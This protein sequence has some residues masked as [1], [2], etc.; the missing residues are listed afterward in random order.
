MLKSLDHV[1]IRTHQLGGLTS[2]YCD[3]LGMTTGPRPSFSFGGAWIYCA[4]RPVVHL[5]LVPAERELTPP[6]PDLQLQHFAFFGSDL[7]AFLERLRHHN[8]AYQIGKL[9]DMQLCQ[10]HLHDPDGNP[11]HIDFPLAEAEQAQV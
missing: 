1:N 9:L 6:S 11:I 5:V 3:V 8:V 10:V 4:G 7:S 2:F